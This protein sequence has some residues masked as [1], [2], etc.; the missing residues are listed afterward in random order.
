[1]KLLILSLFGELSQTKSLSADCP[2]TAIKISRKPE[3]LNP[4]VIRRLSLGPEATLRVAVAAVLELTSMVNDR[5][6]YCVLVVICQ[7]ASFRESCAK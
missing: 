7:E 2:D 4:H 3:T 6:C 5:P 1:M